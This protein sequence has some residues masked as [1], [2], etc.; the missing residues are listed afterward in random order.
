LTTYISATHSPPKV[1]V[2][3]TMIDQ[4]IGARVFE[5]RISVISGSVAT[6]HKF[7]E[8]SLGSLQY[9]VHHGTEVLTAGLLMSNTDLITK[10]SSSRRPLHWSLFLTWSPKQ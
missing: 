6:I 5:A 7:D 10:L 1:S 3:E 8:L 9:T 4:K 2:E